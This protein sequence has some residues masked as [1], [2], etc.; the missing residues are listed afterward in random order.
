MVGLAIWIIS[1][2]IVVS[3]VVGLAYLGLRFWLWN[4]NEK[5]KALALHRERQQE[6]Q[7]K[8]AII[9]QIRQDAW[10][11]RPLTEEEM[12][13][14]LWYL[15]QLKPSELEAAYAEMD[16][17]ERAEL[18]WRRDCKKHGF[19]E[20]DNEYHRKRLGLT[21]AEYS[22]LCLRNLGVTFMIHDREALKAAEKSLDSK[23]ENRFFL[24]A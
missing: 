18:D 6:I 13:T 10:M 22:V 11:N 21:K 14:W 23:L 16:D 20:V 5:D 4:E 24:S 17:W 1:F 7:D 3:T 15:D 2:V 19:G 9:E 8:L 12:D